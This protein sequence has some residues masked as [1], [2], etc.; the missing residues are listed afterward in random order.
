MSKGRYTDATGDRIVSAMRELGSS[1]SVYTQLGISQAVYY[2]WLKDRPDLSLRVELAKREYHE[3]QDIE[4]ISMAKEWLKRLLIE[5]DRTTRKTTKQVVAGGQIFDTEETVKI[6]RPCPSW[7]IDRVL[8]SSETIF[9]AIT[10]LC[11]E[12][13]L[14][15]TA[16]AE[17]FDILRETQN[18][19][20]GIIQNAF[21]QPD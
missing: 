21:E 10:T 19:I 2:R 18:R 1:R 15:D 5:G 20:G 3:L 6:Q 9:K 17:I 13:I 8:G 14:P 12:G 11:T 7:V 4:N 16:A